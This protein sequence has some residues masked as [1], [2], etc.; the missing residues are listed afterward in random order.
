MYFS[1]I[2]QISFLTPSEHKVMVGDNLE[3]DFNVPDGLGKYLN[4]SISPEGKN[5]KTITEEPGKVNMEMKLFDIIP[6]RRVTVNVMPE[7]HVYPSG[8]SIGIVL[9]S[10]GVTAIGFSPINYQGKSYYPARD[11]GIKEGDI[12]TSVNGI[13]VNTDNEIAHVIDKAGRKGQEVEVKLNRNN[14]SKNVI[15]KP[16]YCEKTGRYRAGLYVK[17]KTAGVGTMTFYDAEWGYYG[18]LGHKISENNLDEGLDVIKGRITSAAIRGIQMGRRGSPGEKIGVFIDEMNLQGNITKNCD[19]GIFGKLDQPTAPNSF[20]KEPIPLALAQQAEP[21]Q[22][23]ILTV[24]NGTEVEKFDIEISKII[25]NSSPTNKGMIIRITDPKLLEAT[26]GIVQGMSGSPIIQ[27]GKLVGAITHVF[28]NDPAKGYGI[29]AEWMV[30][31]T[32]ILDKYQKSSN[33]P[34]ENI[35]GIFLSQIN[36]P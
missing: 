1:P 28:V 7:L 32:E 15:L 24:I 18:A 19:L 11:A 31:E 17:D 34:D 9:E 35:G 6:L 16:V 8:E 5:L 21:G 20:Y 14:K 29:F 23:Q 30:K 4:L 3:F 22:A 13:S 2:M 12:I 10:K 26:G 27:N 33:I 36:E 25:N